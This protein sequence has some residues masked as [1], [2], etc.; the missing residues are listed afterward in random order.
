MQLRPLH[1]TGG[2]RRCHLLGQEN[3]LKRQL[4]HVSAFNLCLVMRQ[5]LGAGTHR[6]LKDRAT[7]LILQIF[8]LL[9]GQNRPDSSVESPTSPVLA[10]PTSIAKS[11]L[12]AGRPGIQLL[13]PRTINSGPTR[14]RYH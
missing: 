2:M 10:L 1:E 14:L 13:A 5:R 3:I 9:T 12:E 4:A 7:W 6:E 11:E 8:R